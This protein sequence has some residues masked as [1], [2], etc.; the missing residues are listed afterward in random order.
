MYV[1]GWKMPTGNGTVMRYNQKWL[2]TGW[3]QPS[4]VQAY[5]QGGT[6]TGWYYQTRHC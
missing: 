4:T 5:V 2:C 1:Q 6:L 3:Q